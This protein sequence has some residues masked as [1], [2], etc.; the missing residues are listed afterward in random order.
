MLERSGFEVLEQ[1]S[2]GFLRFHPV[3]AKLFLPYGVSCYSI[4]R[5]RKNYQYPAKRKPDFDPTVFR[6]DLAIFHQHGK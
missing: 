6:P 1:F 2:P 3:I 4:C 5:K